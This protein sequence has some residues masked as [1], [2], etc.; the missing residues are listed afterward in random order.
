VAAHLY[1]C[2]GPELNLYIGGFRKYNR[3]LWLT[4]FSCGDATYTEEQ[5]LQY[6]QQA[7]AILD[8]DPHV[9]RYSWFSGRTTEVANANLLG[10]TGVLTNLGEVYTT[11]NLEGSHNG[12]GSGCRY[13]T[14]GIWYPFLLL[15]IINLLN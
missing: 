11:Q 15:V 4:E 6:M 3:S 12:N 9:F 7:L 13:S 10:A 14:F 8:A 5:Q 1:S 2:T